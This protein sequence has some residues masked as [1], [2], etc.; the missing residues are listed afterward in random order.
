M[1]ETER[2]AG[3]TEALRILA[4]GAL[5]LAL[6]VA[7]TGTV[8]AFDR[9]TGKEFGYNLENAG[10]SEPRGLWSDRTTIW[11]ADVGDNRMVE[12]A[13][14]SSPAVASGTSPTRLPVMTSPAGW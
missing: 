10:N 8:A 2:N 3:V 9:N 1:T 6:A 7:L 4:V 5:M 11:V 12:M 14:R 13:R